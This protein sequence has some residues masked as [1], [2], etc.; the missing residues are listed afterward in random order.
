M[1]EK[2]AQEEYAELAGFQ[3]MLETLDEALRFVNP[4]GGEDDGSAD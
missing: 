2:W 4:D 3:P 1:L